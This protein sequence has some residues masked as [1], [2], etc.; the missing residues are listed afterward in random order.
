MPD[1]SRFKFSVPKG[2][3]FAL[4]SADHSMRLDGFGVLMFSIR[5]ISA[6]ILF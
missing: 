2:T 5:S 4:S 3:S 6:K 1:F